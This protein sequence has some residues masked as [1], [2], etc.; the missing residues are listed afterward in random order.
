[1]DPR[2][3]ETLACLLGAAR[4]SAPRDPA[5]ALAALSAARRLAPDL[6]RGEL[7]LVNAARDDGAT[8]SQISA[9]LSTPNRQTA[10]K[11]HADLARRCPRPPSADAPQAP[12]APGI[13]A[14]RQGGRQ[15]AASPPEGEDAP[16][17]DGQIPGQMQLPLA[18][19][20]GLREPPARRPR[21]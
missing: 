16:A 13:P 11:R 19:A 10:Q 12:P 5:S 2:A 7:A 3:G 4:G 6:E 17:D 9:A 14:L 21:Q 15:P 8:W 1:V 18:L 20:A